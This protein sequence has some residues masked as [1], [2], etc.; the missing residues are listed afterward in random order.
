MPT[1]SSQ[2]SYKLIN[3]NKYTS[4]GTEKETVSKRLLNSNNNRLSIQNHSSLPDPI[5]L[6]IKSPKHTQAIK[7]IVTTPISDTFQFQ[8]ST[9]NDSL[10]ERGSRK[11]R[12]R[13]SKQL[14]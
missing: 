4:K 13:L 1:L 2:C 5:K 6:K 7:P 12:D 10:T 14:Q 11:Q 3:R 8:S 9:S